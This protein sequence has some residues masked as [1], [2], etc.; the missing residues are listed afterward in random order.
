[1]TSENLKIDD[2]PTFFDLKDLGPSDRESYEW[3]EN[4]ADDYDQNVGLT[5]KSLGAG[6][7]FAHR[8]KMWD[9]LQVRAGHRILEIGA[10]TG[11]DS[12]GIASLMDASGELHITE[13]YREMLF[14]ARRKL[15]DLENLP[16]IYFSAVDA[17]K[18]PFEDEYF[19]SVFHFG[20]LNTFSN[21]RL[22]LSE[23]A[24]VT[25]DGGRVV[26]GDESI[27]RWLRNFEKM[28]AIS[29]SNPL[30]LF[31]PPLES[32][33]SEARELKLEYLFGDGF[34]LVS[35]T[36]SRDEPGGDIDFPIPGL[37]GGTLRTRLNGTLE[38]VGPKQKKRIYEHANK[39]GTSVH[40]I[41]EKLIDGHLT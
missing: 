32:I 10:G 15:L 34:Y 29:N 36:V 7:E 14:D 27:P 35:F 38:G 39:S 18:L 31:D 25:K 13:V 20:G 17:H 23:W 24:R 5:F 33:P 6:D 30:F 37:R 41:L 12:A 28:R 40:D 22:A 16:K 3:Y 8:A 11:R 26:F 19:D 4:N 2:I 9:R 21:Q 1:M